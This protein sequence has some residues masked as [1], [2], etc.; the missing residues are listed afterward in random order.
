M[1]T[2]ALFL[3]RDGVLNENR[4]DY[5][6]SWEE[7]R[8]LPRSLDALAVLS[9]LDVPILLVTHQSMIGRGHAT[10]SSLEDIHRRMLG[11]IVEW[12]GRVD[13]SLFCP[14]VPDVGCQCRKPRPGMLFQ[15][16]RE[17][18]ISL[19]R[20]VLIGDALTDFQLAMAADVRYIH[21]C[22][23]L[24]RRDLQVIQSIDPGVHVVADLADDVPICAA[25]LQGETESA[26]CPN[27]ARAPTSLT[28]SFEP[29]PAP[30]QARGAAHR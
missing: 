19:P 12:G 11:Q 18:D 8:W 28:L 26:A 4:D 16:A 13:A 20:S 5:V 7:F 23:G 15:V 30:G 2:A 9:R 17:R 22:S 14:H 27:V 6:K 1:A 3:D 10:A 21:V 29:R 24:G 25:I